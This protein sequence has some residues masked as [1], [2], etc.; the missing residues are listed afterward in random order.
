NGGAG[1]PLGDQQAFTLVVRTSNQAPV[2]L[3]AGNPSVQAGQPLS[4]PFGAVD[5]DGDALT[6]SAVNLPAGAQLNPATGI[7]S[8][9]PGLAQVGK[10]TGIVLKAT[11]GNLT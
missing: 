4:V 1:Q 3:P 5:P 7:L 8:W 2:W 11:D 9:A 10:H 6:Y